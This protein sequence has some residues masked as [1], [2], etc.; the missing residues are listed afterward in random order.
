MLEKKYT[1]QAIS[2]RKKAVIVESEKSVLQLDTNYGDDNY[3]VALYGKSISERKKMLLL[4]L[5]ISELIIGLDWDYDTIFE[6][7]G[8]TKTADFL[9][10]MKSVI[11]IYE[12]F[13]PF[14]KCTLLLS[15]NG[16]KKN[17]SP[18]DY[19]KTK[20]EWTYKNRFMI[21]RNKDK[22]SL[23]HKGGYVIMIE[24]EELK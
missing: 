3:S 6:S 2:R 15:N 12:V 24:K 1:K 7:D 19:D 17:Q 23:T 10:Y 21:N 14:V 20:F 9:K 22:Y 5:G 16:H 8:K 13:A 11:K 4:E 18:T